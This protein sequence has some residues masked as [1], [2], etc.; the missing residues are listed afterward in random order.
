MSNLALVIVK[1][2]FK[3]TSLPQ[4][5]TT[6]S[7]DFTK[8]ELKEN[9][10][11][12]MFESGSS[13]SHQVHWKLYDALGESIRIEKLEARYGKALSSKMKRS[14]DD[15][16]PPKNHDGE[17]KKRRRK[18]TR[19][20]SSKKDKAQDD[21]SDIE[22]KAEKELPE[23][24]WFNKLV[25]AEEEP[26]EH[27]LQNGSVV[28]FGK[29][30]KKFLNKDKITKEDLE[31]K[32]DWANP[33]GN[34]FHDD[35]SKPLPLVGHPV[36]KI[37]AARCDQEGIEEMI[38][39]LWSPSIQKYN[40]DDELGIHHWDEHR[41]WFYKG[42]IRQKSRHEVHSK[43]NIISV[44]RIK[45]NKKYGYTY[46][47]EIVVKRTDQKEYM[48]AKADFPHLN[49]NDIEDLYLLKI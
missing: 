46:L 22:R 36:T 35:L 3:T 5:A 29:C 37:K 1:E 44:H 26:E 42:N 10:Y 15:Q 17:K 41:Q 4:D 13:I 8:L 14:Y 49:Q 7:N 34:R 11:D 33:K 28:L 25:D 32:I 40:I 43:L 19:E 27:R 45:V 9:L 23:Q 47:E 18:D 39:Y 30:M 20:S 38:P 48:F 6:T 24:S 16:D 2:A 12:M 21:T 31:D